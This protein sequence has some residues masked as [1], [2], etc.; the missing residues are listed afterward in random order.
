M[1]TMTQRIEAGA[2]RGH[3]LTF[4]VGG[5]HIRVPY[6]QLHDEARAVRRQ[7]PGPGRSVPGDHVALLGPPSAPARHRDPGDLAERA[8]RV[9]VLPLPMRM[10]SIEE[11]VGQTRLRITNA[12]VSLVLVDPE[13]APF[14]E[15]VAG[16]P[17][18]G[19]R[20]TPC[21]RAP[22]GRGAGAW[23]RPADDLDRLAILQFTSGSTSDPKGVMLPHRTVGANLDAIALATSLDPD[24]DVLVSWLPALPRHGPGRAASA[25][26]SRPGHAAGAR[27]RPRTSWPAPGA[28]WSGS[29]DLRRHRHRRPQL[30]L[31]PRGPGAAPGRA[32][33][34]VAPADRAQRRRAGRPRHRARA[35]STPASATACDPAA[36][37]PAFGM[38]EVAIA[39][40]FPEP[41]SRACAP[42]P[43]TSG[44]SR[45]SGT[46]PPSDHD[47]DGR[48]PAWRSSGARSPGLEI[49]GGRPR[50]RRR[51]AATARSASSSIR[52]T[53]VTPGLLQAARRQRRALPRR[54]APHR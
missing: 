2:D 6:R 9:V 10:S 31:R 4:V 7:P 18:D 13:L 30:L 1:L 38:A 24:D 3:D 49:R 46:P 21:S 20:G 36:V 52:G 51:A 22:D 35:S 16:R 5:D 44:S 42:T 19:R 14:I 40:T 47:A 33:R 48:A 53:S 28:G 27:A 25:S 15:P 26:R 45:P 29:S 17:A 54:L 11:F 32:A 41:V 8:R 23:E 34:P 43:S 39:G 12:D 37:F 50:D